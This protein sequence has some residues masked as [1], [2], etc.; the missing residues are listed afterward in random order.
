MSQFTKSFSQIMDQLTTAA[1]CKVYHTLASMRGV[2]KIKLTNVGLALRSNVDPKSI[3]E[4]T[5]KLQ[6]IGAISVTVGGTSRSR[7]TYV[8]TDE[9]IANQNPNYY[10][11]KMSSKTY[12]PEEE[13]DGL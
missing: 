4:I 2:G 6:K 1:Q 5:A 9:T 3:P 12:A 8:M 11:E 13:E 7:K 10:R